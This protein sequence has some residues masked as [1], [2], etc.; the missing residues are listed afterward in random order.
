MVLL[1]LYSG[2]P[3]ME[4]QLP[5]TIN[6]GFPQTVLLKH[7][8][9][10]IKANQYMYLLDLAHFNDNICTNWE[11]LRDVIEIEK[12]EKIFFLNSELTCSWHFSETA[13]KKVTY[14]PLLCPSGLKIHSSAARQNH[15]CILWIKEISFL[16][17]HTQFI[18]IYLTE[19]THTRQRLGQNYFFLIKQNLPFTWKKNMVILQ[20]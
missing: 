19:Y 20:S 1:L 18:Q 2:V 10:V 9:I 15:E 12:I 11:H 6:Q 4:H 3:S 16:N 14:L 5:S 17:I 13:L 8:F 7:I